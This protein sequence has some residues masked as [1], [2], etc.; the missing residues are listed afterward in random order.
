MSNRVVIGLDLGHSS[1]KMTFDG[2]HGVEREIFSSHV[3]RADNIESAEEAYFFKQNLV[4]V[5]GKLFFVGEASRLHCDAHQFGLN[6]SRIYSEEY[7]ALI[8]M[9][10]RIADDRAAHRERIWV[11]GLPFSDF[12]RQKDDVVDILMRYLGGNPEVYVIPKF[13]GGYYAHTLN[14]NGESA[15]GNDTQKEGWGIIDVGYY[16]S[17]F[18]LINEGHRILY[19]EGSCEGL[20]I[21]TEK[22]QKLLL[23]NYKI[24]CNLFDAERAL[25]EGY[26]KNYRQRIFIEKEIRIAKRNFENKI[27][28]TALHFM[29]NMAET[30]DGILLTGGGAD[31]VLES[32][33]RQWPHTKIIQDDHK[34]VKKNSSQYIASEGYYRYGK[35]IQ[36]KKHKKLVK[37]IS[38][39]LNSIT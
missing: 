4:E 3:C 2:R 18:S 31:F 14:C 21:V 24:D 17:D 26:I 7:A 32:I 38:D 6:D 5:N 37:D 1:V 13:M 28:D 16:K 12:S 39:E 29:G 35:S 8:K 15:R 34:N 22:L 10:K 30:I 23:E 19:T 11:V 9:A 36:L 25:Y 27:A 20:Y 33:Y